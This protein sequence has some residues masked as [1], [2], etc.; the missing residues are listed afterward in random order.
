MQ[1]EE[2][3]EDALG[4]PDRD[5]AGGIGAEMEVLEEEGEEEQEEEELPYDPIQVS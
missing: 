2:L 3:A 1:G 5:E 4:T